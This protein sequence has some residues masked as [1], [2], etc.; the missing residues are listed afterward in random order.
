[1]STIATELPY[2]WISYADKAGDI[3]PLYHFLKGKI[4]KE[5]DSPM[6]EVWDYGLGCC[7]E[8]LIR[9]GY[10]FKTLREGKEPLLL[11][12]YE[13]PIIPKPCH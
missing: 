13:N 10:Q 4:K 9:F 12:P 8:M 11:D 2:A 1:M 7:K 5:P 6:S 3:I